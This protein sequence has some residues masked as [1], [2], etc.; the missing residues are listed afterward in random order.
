MM[1][2]P[3]AWTRFVDAVVLTAFSAALFIAVALLRR[4][5]RA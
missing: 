1:K 5:R 4:F 2:H 3:S